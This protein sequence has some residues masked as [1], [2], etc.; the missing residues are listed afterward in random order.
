MFNCTYFQ[1]KEADQNDLMDSKLKCVFALPPG[2]EQN[3]LEDQP[4]ALDI[5]MF[6]IF[7]IGL[8]M[9]IILGI[10]IPLPVQSASIS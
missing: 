4:S 2:Q 3:N 9:I 10:P 1:W 6:I 7:I 5:L 8:T